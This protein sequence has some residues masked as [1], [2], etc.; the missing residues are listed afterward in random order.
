MKARGLQIVLLAM[1]ALAGASGFAPSAQAWSTMRCGNRL[2]EVGD[3]LYKVK[4]VCGQPDQEDVSVT[5]RTMRHRVGA[6][7]RVVQGRQHC[8]DIYSE[9]TVE[10]PVH[11][12]TYDFGRNRFVHYLRFESGRLVT[13]ESGDYG[14][15][16]PR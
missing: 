3:P 15:K 8:Q 16:S 5:Y 10:V 6:T 14:V 4:E 2:V 13:V 11:Q 12:L 1:G 9:H 7:C